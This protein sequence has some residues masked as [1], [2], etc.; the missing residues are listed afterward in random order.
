MFGES[1]TRTRCWYSR[2]SQL[3]LIGLLNGIY[4]GDICRRRVTEEIIRAPHTAAI[5]ASAGPTPHA[6]RIRSRVLAAT[7]SGTRVP[8]PCPP[9]LTGTG[10]SCVVGP[11]R[12]VRMAARQISAQMAEDPA[13]PNSLYNPPSTQTATRRSCAWA[14]A[15]A[16][17]SRDLHEGRT[18]PPR[19][20]TC[21]SARTPGGA[22]LLRKQAC[23]RGVTLIV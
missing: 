10:R 6:P 16:C 20:H 14:P 7:I 17:V 4:V 18:H 12:S 3:F 11:A 22:Y 1:I 19:T 13:C 15:R 2:P 5:S 23:L 21:L 8:L 9:G